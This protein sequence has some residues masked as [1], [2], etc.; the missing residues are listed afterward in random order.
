MAAAAEAIEAQVAGVEALTP[1]EMAAADREILA[2]VMDTPLNVMLFLSV[3]IGVAVMGLTAYTAIVDR[4]R[5]YGVLKAIG[6]GGGRLARL[7]VLET[8][9]RAVLGFVL[10]IGL[11][12]LTADPIMRLWPQFAIVIRPAGVAGP[13]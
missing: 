8:L 7:V 9:Y 6:A 3:V 12:Y 4:M 10:G 11:S 1:A 13:A 5:E 2:A